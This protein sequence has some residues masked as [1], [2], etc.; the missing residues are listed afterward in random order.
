MI[1]GIKTLDDIEVSGKTVLLR[2]D[3]NCPIDTETKRI[4][5]D[6][7]IRRSLPTIKELSEKKA[8]IVILAHQADPLDYQNFTS[9][10]EHSQILA[11]LL[12]KKIEFIDD[13]VGPAAR[14]AIKSLKDGEI[15]LLENIR[16]LTEETII[17]EKEVGLSPEEQSR[18]LLPQK[19]APLADLYICDAF[20]CVHRAEPSL[21]GLPLILPSGCGR[22][23]EEELKALSAVVK[24]PKRPC[25][26]I[27]GGAKI[28]DA[29]KMMKKSLEKGIADKVLTA[30]LVGEIMLKAKGYTLGEPSEELIRKKN[31]T[32]FINTAKDILGEYKD[33]VLFPEDV[34]TTNG[35]R[36]EFSIEELPLDKLITDIGTKTVGKYKEIIKKAATIFINGPA[37]VYEEKNSEKGTKEIWQTVGENK[38]FSVVGGGDTISAC[39]RFKVEDKVSYISTAGG[40]L[41]RYLSGEK[42]PVI[43]ALKH[44]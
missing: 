17:F 29:F 21:V 32:S 20:A 6:T 15:L 37:G 30:G 38:T 23:F 42:L 39:K 8:K 22:L 41:I 44:K 33:K 27:L 19:L 25:I 11:K 35:G 26:F 28:L 13:V 1:A 10:R 3:I 12:G 36:L 2:V 5:D 43:E 16:Y 31:L 9:L 40:G 14:E 18:T 4:K 24:Q 7:R 34:A